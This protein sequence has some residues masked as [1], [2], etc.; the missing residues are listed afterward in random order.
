MFTKVSL[1][2]QQ[3]TI[4]FLCKFTHGH[5]LSGAKANIRIPELAATPSPSS[6]TWTSFIECQMCHVILKSVRDLGIHKRENHPPIIRQKAYSGTA[7]QAIPSPA[8]RGNQKPAQSP[9][10]LLGQ[11]PCPVCKIGCN[12]RETHLGHVSVEHPSYK[13]MCDE[14]NCLKAYVS[15]FCRITM[16]AFY[17]WTVKKLS[18]V[19]RTVTIMNVQLG[20]QNQN[21]RMSL[22]LNPRKMLKVKVKAPQVSTANQPLIR[23]YIQFCHFS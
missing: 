16:T 8:S 14:A 9:V 4:N 7:D 13:F 21:R 5:F 10:L 11:I 1:F 20:F 12:D 23:L 6:I 18:N 15:K 2:S 22:K 17:V 19:K 3:F